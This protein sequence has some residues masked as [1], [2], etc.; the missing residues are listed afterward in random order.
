MNIWYFCWEWIIGNSSPIIY[1][2]FLLIVCQSCKIWFP[3]LFLSLLISS[4]NLSTNLPGQPGNRSPRIKSS[5]F[6]VWELRDYNKILEKASMKRYW[7]WRL[8]VL[9]NWVKI[10]TFSC[11][12]FLRRRLLVATKITNI[13]DLILRLRLFTHPGKFLFIYL[14]KKKYLTSPP[15]MIYL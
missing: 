15:A 9:Y 12:P 3:G 2:F 11:R 13:D 14:Y 8:C 7:F 6:V 10:N 1:S 4:T 5:I